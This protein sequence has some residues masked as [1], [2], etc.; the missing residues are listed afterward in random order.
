MKCTCVRVSLGLYVIRVRGYLLITTVTNNLPPLFQSPYPEGGGACTLTADFHLSITIQRVPRP[1]R[2]SCVSCRFFSEEFR[3][4]VLAASS[5]FPSG[6]FK[7]KLQPGLSTIQVSSGFGLSGSFRT[8]TKR[9]ASYDATVDGYDGT[10]EGKDAQYNSP[11]GPTTTGDAFTATPGCPPSAPSSTTSTRVE[12]DSPSPR[13]VSY[14]QWRYDAYLVHRGPRMTF[15]PLVDFSSVFGGSSY[16]AFDSI[17]SFPVVFGVSYCF[18]R[19]PNNNNITVLYVHIPL[20]FL[21]DQ[22]RMML[23]HTIDDSPYI[24]FQVYDDCS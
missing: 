20:R 2:C 12:R 23:S 5:Q 22:L 9:P 14:S 21:I 10:Y 19:A 15:D 13:T 4:T 3:K 1:T 6:G 8:P 11:D 24:V 16:D 17:Q 7:R 18:H